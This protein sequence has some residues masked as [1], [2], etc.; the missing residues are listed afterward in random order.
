MARRPSAA[1]GSLV[2]RVGVYLIAACAIVLGA[3]GC[4]AAREDYANLTADDARYNAFAI[5]AR[6]Q[7][8]GQAPREARIAG[9]YRDVRPNGEEAWLALLDIGNE[10]EDRTCLA[11]WAGR[12]FAELVHYRL[13]SCRGLAP[14][15]KP[16]ETPTSTDR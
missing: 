13:F 3:V 2:L 10:A 14:L 7:H 12:P 15:V 4:D 9:I 8:E 16:T 6:L 1:L 11:I 5:L